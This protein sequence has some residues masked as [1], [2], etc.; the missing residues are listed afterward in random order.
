MSPQTKH[1]LALWPVMLL[2]LLPAASA[3][4]GVGG[5]GARGAN[6]PTFP[7][8]M[9]TPSSAS[10]PTTTPAIVGPSLDDPALSDRERIN[11]LRDQPIEGA[12]VE[13]RR[14]LE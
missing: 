7:T 8:P 9:G 3:A 4:R 13:R 6:L 5:E 2:M 10:A 11:L 12:A 1:L 14:A